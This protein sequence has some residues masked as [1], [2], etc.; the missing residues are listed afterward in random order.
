MPTI[1]QGNSISSPNVDSSKSYVDGRRLDHLEAVGGMAPDARAVADRVDGIIDSLPVDGRDQI[2]EMLRMEQPSHS[3]TLFPAEQVLF[4]S[5]WKSLEL[6]AVTPATAGSYTTPAPLDS[7]VRL[8]T[9]V[10]GLDLTQS[11]DITRLPADVQ[12]VARRIQ[13]VLNSDTDATTISLADVR[14][15]IADPGR[16]TPA[17]QQGFTV[18]ERALDQ[19]LR[20]QP[21]GMTAQLRVPKPGRK[22]QAIPH[23]GQGGFRLATE[24]TIR[25]SIH[26]FHGPR[27]VE[28]A[29]VER[30]QTIQVTVPAGHQ[31]ILLN[32]DGDGE[33]LADAGTSDISLDPGRHR[34]ELWQN[35][36]RIESSEVII[37]QYTH[38]A[39]HD[40][41]R[42]IGVP[43][44]AGTTQLERVEVDNVSRG[45]G[46]GTTSVA[47]Y[48]PVGSAPSA[49]VKP[50]ADLNN[51]RTTL[52]PGVYA[53]PQSSSKL[54]VYS[55]TLVSVLDGA[56]N[57]WFL[58][59]VNDD[60]AAFVDGNG[61]HAHQRYAAHSGQ[62][63]V[64]VWEGRNR[65]QHVRLQDRI[66]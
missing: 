36:Q 51:F 27:Q 39:V 64:T 4:G 7:L 22:T 42:T 59:P 66:D 33:V 28:K 3:A 57:E 13:L 62:G 60:R 14:Q 37:P 34:V 43:M 54:H 47:E 21:A 61:A 58:Y 65:Y 56:A 35:S 17:D 8:N 2:D 41:R 49:Q 32:L 29:E 40:I 18:I 23:A 24:V 20:N 52:P 31:M 48:R 5:L 44:I 10:G 50:I 19:I 53:I 15:A 12:T 1:V 46:N 11:I 45:R 26:I 6:E 55:D 38:R 9:S 25:D 63:Y 16:F 30:R